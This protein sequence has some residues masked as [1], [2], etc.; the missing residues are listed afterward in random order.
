MKIYISG[1]ITGLDYSEALK[2][3]E[4]AEFILKSDTV[5]VVNP[6]TIKHDHDKSWGNSCEKILRLC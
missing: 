1:K 6:M 2:K 4:D 5:E 3:F